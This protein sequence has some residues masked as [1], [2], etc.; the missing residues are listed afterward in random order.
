MLNLEELL[1]EIC[2]YYEYTLILEDGV[3][4][5]SGCGKEYTFPNVEECLI[6]WLP[7]IVETNI[8]LI[9][10]NKPTVWSL[11]KI[12]VIMGL[13]LR[14]DRNVTFYKNS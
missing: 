14:G 5:I 8:S 4:Y 9:Q 13:K 6:K 3:V 11:E 7:I 1:K 12:N 2:E 10:R